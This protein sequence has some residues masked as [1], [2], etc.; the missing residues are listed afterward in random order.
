MAMDEEGYSMLESGDE[1]D[2]AVLARKLEKS[3]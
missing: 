2:E 3:I 1:A